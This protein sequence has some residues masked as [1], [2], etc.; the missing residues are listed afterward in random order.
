MKVRRRFARCEPRVTARGSWPDCWRAWNVRSAGCWP[1]TPRTGD[2]YRQR[3]RQESPAA[4]V[5]RRPPGSWRH[6]R[7][8]A[9]PPTRLPPDC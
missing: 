6:D 8:S 9:R 7:E 3:R 2:R 1:T 4:G 5:W